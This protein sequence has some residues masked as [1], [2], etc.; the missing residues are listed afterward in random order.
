MRF[1]PTT[2]TFDPAPAEI[3]IGQEATATRKTCES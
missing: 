1:S 2:D 3:S